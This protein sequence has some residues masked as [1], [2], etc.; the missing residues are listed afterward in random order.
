MDNDLV[1]KR[2]QAAEVLLETEAF[3][4]T[5]NELYNQ[6]LNDITMSKL[7]EN[8]VREQRFYQIRA[9]QDIQAALQSWV[10]AKTE[11]VISLTEE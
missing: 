1:M 7:G 11:L 6:Y 10:N 8:E 2:G 9:L 5:V 3:L 4:V